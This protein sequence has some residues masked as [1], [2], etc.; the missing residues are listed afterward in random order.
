MRDLARKQEV[1]L[2]TDAQLKTPRTA[3]AGLCRNVLHEAWAEAVPE[4][5]GLSASSVSR[6]FMRASARKWRE[7][8]ERRWGAEEVVVLCLDGKT[9][10]ED[11]MVLALGGTRPGEKKILGW[12]Q[13]AT[14]NESVCAAF[15]RGLV[16]RGLR[17]DQGRRCVIDGAQGLRK[18][19]QTVFGRQAVVQRGQWPKR[20]KGVRDL[21]KGPQA[22]WR[23][24]VPQA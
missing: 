9:F 21:P 20:E 4:A 17:T 7:L 16:T 23:R 11:P 3:D 2:A 12:V 19:S 8:S 13:T 15:L 24:R 1:P 10:A 22:T 6:R 14:E 18:A 5:F